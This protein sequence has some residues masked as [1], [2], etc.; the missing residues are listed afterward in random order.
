M[1]YDN[2]VKTIADSF[3]S[4]KAPGYLI[5]GTREWD[6]REIVRARAGCC[7]TSP[8]SFEAERLIAD[9]K[10]ELKAQGV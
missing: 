2:Y 6:E 10:A 4:D 9:I 5:R 1:E 3:K 8:S 7:C